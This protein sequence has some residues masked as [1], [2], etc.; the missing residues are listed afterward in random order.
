MDYYV[1]ALF[2][3]IKMWMKDLISLY[4]RRWVLVLRYPNKKI[5]TC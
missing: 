1:D 5:I 3:I 2:L 4:L